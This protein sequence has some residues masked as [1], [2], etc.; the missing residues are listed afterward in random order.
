MLFSVVSG[1]VYS[2][3]Y[4]VCVQM[5]AS[6]LGKGIKRIPCSICA[7]WWRS[8]EYLIAPCRVLSSD[9]IAVTVVGSACTVSVLCMSAMCMIMSLYSPS[10]LSGRDTVSK[11]GVDN[12]S[13]KEAGER[14]TL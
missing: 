5:C 8:L 4:S 13:E 9:M 3:A 2:V 1:S 12:D 11:E 7:R 6:A 10:V 14:A